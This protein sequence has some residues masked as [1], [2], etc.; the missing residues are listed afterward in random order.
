MKSF[1]TQAALTLFWL[2]ELACFE[3]L[4][5]NGSS[6]IRPLNAGRLA[7]NTDRDFCIAASNAHM[8]LLLH[9]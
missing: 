4:Q 9:G 5:I 7:P 6:F 2:C 3:H 8:S 1:T